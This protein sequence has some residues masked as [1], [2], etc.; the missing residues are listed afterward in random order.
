MK[1][2]SYMRLALCVS[3]L[4]AALAC[5]SR[6]SG[7][8]RGKSTDVPQSLFP[9]RLEI[10][11]CAQNGDDHEIHEYKAFTLCYRESYELSEWAAYELTREELAVTVSRSNNFRSDPSISTGSALPTDYAKTGYDRG[12]LAPAADMRFDAEA[13]SESF[14]MSN[15]APQTPALNRYM[16]KAAED[17]TRSLAREHGRVWVVSGP[18]LER[19]DYKTIGLSGVSVPDYF[20]KA[21]LFPVEEE[22][23]YDVVAFIMPNHTPS[24]NH[25]DYLVSID[26]IEARTG[27]D[28][29]FALDNE[30]ELIVEARVKNADS[31]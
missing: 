4:A 27:L 30:I 5:V 23:G 31:S 29:F 24:K 3:V 19:D 21:I 10:P 9:A 17:M 6:F 12:H 15:M 8:A 2:K 25:Q 22:P 18:V 11:R 14:F 28:L 16:W 1:K 13:M 26:E 7:E 20:Y